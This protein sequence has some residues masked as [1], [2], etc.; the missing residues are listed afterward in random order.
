MHLVDHKKCGDL[1]K[2]GEE[3]TITKKDVP[4]DVGILDSGLRGFSEE[5][6]E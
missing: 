6:V 5:D 3:K 1:V 4:N 2:G